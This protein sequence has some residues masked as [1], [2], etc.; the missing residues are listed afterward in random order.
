MG[1][2]STLKARRKFS[3]DAIPIEWVCKSYFKIIS[4]QR[5]SNH[6][7]MTHGCCPVIIGGKVTFS[8][9]VAQKKTTPFKVS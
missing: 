3:N 1:V 7:F 6:V 4:V 5:T 2:G 9:R 8:A